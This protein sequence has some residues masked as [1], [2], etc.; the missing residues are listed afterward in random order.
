MPYVPQHAAA[1]A[2]RRSN[3]QICQR[4]IERTESK[5][6]LR[7]QLERPAQKV[8]NDIGMTYNDFVF[9]LCRDIR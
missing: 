4:A 6:R 1:D 3:G 5:P 2:A 8:A 9:M 7:W